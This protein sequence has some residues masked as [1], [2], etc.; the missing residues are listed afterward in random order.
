MPLKYCSVTVTVAVY[1]P[2][3]GVTQA[4]G[5]AE[6][7]SVWAE[8]SAGNAKNSE[9]AATMPLIERLL[10]IST[11]SLRSLDVRQTTRF[12]R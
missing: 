8:D 4:D 10:T 7:D 11:H 1:V 3:T 5:P 6:T 2:L 12:L 9:K